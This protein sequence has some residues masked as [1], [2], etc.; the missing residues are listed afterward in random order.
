MATK[1]YMEALSPTMEE[2]RLI[3]WLKN[4]G[5]QVNEGDV[6][7]EVETDKATME[8]VARGGGVLRKR[9]I[10]EG[11]TAN[12]GTIIAV[13]AGEGEDISSLTGADAASDQAP[14]TTEAPEKVPSAEEAESD[15]EADVKQGAAAV[16]AAGQ[17]E[18]DQAEKGTADR[19]APGEKPTPTPDRKTQ[20]ARGEGQPS[21]VQGNDRRTAADAGDGRVKASPLARRLAAENGLEIGDVRGSGPG[22]RIVKADIEAALQEVPAAAAAPAETPV[23][24]APEAP[25]PA[26][27][28][29]IAAEAYRDLPL[30]QMRKTIARRLTQSIGPVPHF[31]LTI[32]VDMGEAMQLRQRINER[33]KEEG[34]KVSPNDLIIKAVAAALRRHPWVNSAWTGDAVRQYDVVH[35]GV[36]VAVE[37]GL[38]T[39]VIR[40]ADRK[41]VTEIAQEVKELAGRAREKKL[42]PEEYT[43]STFS[44]SN[45]GMFGIEEFTAVINP[46][47]A[48][49]LAVGAVQE[50][51]VVENGEM[52]VRQRMR[53]TMSCDHRVIDGATGAQF[54][55]TLKR[56]LEDPMMMI[57]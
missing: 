9:M 38:I 55:Q 23:E 15:E 2:G 27:P 53:V 28:Q 34:I 11:D 29:P 35:I 46:P 24:R 6:L 3:T 42:K 20:P 8:L 19:A 56:Y 41:G 22:G 39:P 4:E 17:T 48:A 32:E 16:A 47:E 43:G 31:F 1:V 25:A 30:S 10:G 7:A 54:L 14:A 36:A 52:A 26:A 12:V 57:A 21:I 51:V 40:D 18:R 13:I 45:L 44:I 33:F 5:D 49:I 50:K 37:E